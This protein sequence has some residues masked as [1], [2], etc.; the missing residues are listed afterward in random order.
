MFSRLNEAVPLNSAE[1]RNAFGGY[2]VKAI[3]DISQHELFT[4]KVR[5]NNRRFQH[6]EIAAR[7][8]LVEISQ[9]ENNKLIDTKKVYL[10]AMA[11]NYRT[12]NTDRVEDVKMKVSFV[13]NLM[14]NLYVEQDILLRAQGSMVVNYLLFKWANNNGIAITRSTLL[15]FDDS[16]KSNKII[17]EV[18]YEAADYDLL[19]FDRLNLYGTNDVSNIKERY[20]IISEFVARSQPVI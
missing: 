12:E 4:K 11:K 5:F 17:A 15:N 2:M 9:I 3:R 8:L 6:Y 10:D 13:L 16:V 18:D 14:N 20:R 7:L 1:K 19:E